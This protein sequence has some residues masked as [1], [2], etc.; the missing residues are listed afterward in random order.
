VDYDSYQTK[1]NYRNKRT[2]HTRSYRI[3]TIEQVTLDFR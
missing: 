2:T 1:K 3:S